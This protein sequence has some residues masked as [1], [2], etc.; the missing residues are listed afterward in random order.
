MK[1]L[2]FCSFILI[3]ATSCTQLEKKN[4]LFTEMPSSI[5]HIDFRNEVQEN[6]DYNIL[7]YEYLYNGAGVAVGDLNGDGLPDL[8]FTCNM[9]PDKL[10]LNRGGFQFEDVAAQAGVQGR[11]KWKTGAVIA[12]VNGDGLPDIY[13]CYSGPGTDEDRRKELYINQGVKNGIPSRKKPKNLDWTHP[14]RT[15][16]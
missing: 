16:R 13:V 15:L 11:P 9:G 12:D 8:Y 10:Y 5:T 4:T 3:L 7:T 14:A 1:I 6:V 2:R